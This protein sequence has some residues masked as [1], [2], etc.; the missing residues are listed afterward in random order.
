[1]KKIAFV[2]YRNWAFEI[3]K[4]IA[5]FQKTRDDFELKVLITTPEHE[6]SLEEAQKYV[7][8]HV[9]NGNN[10]A[11][12][13]KIL[14][15]E[16]IDAAFFYGWSWIVSKEITDNFLC[17]V[18]HPS[19]LPKYRGGTPIQHQLVAGEATSA[20][21]VFKMSGGIDDGDIYRQL[22]MDLAG[23]INDIFKRM[24]D[25]GT[26]ITKGFLLDL[27]KGQ[28]KFAAQENLEKYPPLKRRKPQDSEI[29]LANLENLRFQDVYNLVRGLLDP[30]PNVYIS[31]PKRRINILK[32]ERAESPAKDAWVLTNREPLEDGSFDL[33]GRDIFLKLKDGYAKLVEFKIEKL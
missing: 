3:F 23:D 28:L 7:P 8:A 26:K 24:A 20:V 19:P 12:I 5:D 2:I 16:K 6:F 22:P 32:V 9:V 14:N 18:L 25:L 13:L 27:A 31:L 11:G 17:L 30:F 33:N 29:K 1:M 15:D 21:T 4:C 10:N